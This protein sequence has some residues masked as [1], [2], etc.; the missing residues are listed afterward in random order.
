MDTKFNI[1][2]LLKLFIVVTLLAGTFAYVPS[3]F[4]QETCGDTVTVVRGDTLF[5]IAVRCGTSVNALMRANPDIKNRSLIYPGQ[6]IVLPGAIIPGT[7]KTDIY[8]IKRGDT[9]SKLAVEFKTTVAKLL[10]LNPDIVDRSLIYAGQRLVVP[11][12][13]IGP[14]Q[15]YVANSRETLET[16]AKRFQI[17]VEILLQVNPDIKDPTKT[18]PRVKVYLPNNI[19]I[20]TVKAGDTLSEIAKEHNIRLSELLEL[21]T[22]ITNRN[23]I[24]R[25]WILR[26]E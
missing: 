21:N 20:Y 6:V 24:Y 19:T 5:K 14:G 8:I 17:T 2:K 3:A 13:R 1:A 7:G 26:V 10:E 23:L 16:I 9:L 22:W 4:A 15:I 25:G 18:L 12:D 11:T